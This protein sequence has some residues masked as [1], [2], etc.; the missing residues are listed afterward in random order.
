MTT[1]SNEWHFWKDNPPP[2]GTVVLA[3]WSL[4]EEWERFRTC[5][6]GCCVHDGLSSL[7]L[8]N[9]WKATED[10]TSPLRNE[11]SPIDWG[12]FELYD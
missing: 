5:K 11:G 3:C 9:F 1:L 10:Q 7:V 12:L 8:P 2:R 6:R 4:S